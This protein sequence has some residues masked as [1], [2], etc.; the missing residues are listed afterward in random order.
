V[1]ASAGVG[2]IVYGFGGPTDADPNGVVNVSY[3][4]PAG[5]DLTNINPVE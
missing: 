3:G 1:E 2:I 5:L 4:Y